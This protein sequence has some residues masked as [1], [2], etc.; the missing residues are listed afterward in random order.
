MPNLAPGALCL[1][2]LGR[3]QGGTLGCVVDR[4]AVKEPARALCRPWAR[5]LSLCSMD[6]DM[7]P[8][9]A[10]GGAHPLGAHAPTPVVSGVVCRRSTLPTLPSGVLCCRV[11]ACGM[12][13]HRLGLWSMLHHRWGC[14]R[15]D[16]AP[17]CVGQPSCAPLGWWWCS[18]GW[19]S[20]VS[21]SPSHAPRWWVS[22]SAGCRCGA[23]CEGQPGCVRWFGLGFGV[24]HCAGFPLYRKGET[25]HHSCRWC[26]R[27]AQCRAMRVVLVAFPCVCRGSGC[28]YCATRFAQCRAMCLM[29][30]CRADLLRDA[31]RAIAGVV[32]AQPAAICLGVLGG[33]PQRK[34]PTP[35]W[36]GVG[37]CS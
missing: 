20:V 31:F 28:P 24:W 35:G 30:W 15:V 19:G 18:S 6:I 34:R 17:G 2:Q 33:G 25:P 23:R 11:C 5:S 4:G 8:C 1:R 26:E 9:P 36:S 21:V 13:G 7:G 10:G 37:R 32:V 12:S 29:V 3:E 14:G 22:P 27:F 16:V